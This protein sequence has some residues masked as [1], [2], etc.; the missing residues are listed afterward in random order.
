MNR[1][2]ADELLLQISKLRIGIAK[3]ER[4]KQRMIER[5]VGVKPHRQ[6]MP[7]FFPHPRQRTRTVILQN[8]HPVSVAYLARRQDALLPAPGREIELPRI[9]RPRWALKHPRHANDLPR[10]QARIRM[11]DRQKNSAARALPTVIRVNGPD[12]RHSRLLRQQRPQLRRRR[13]KQSRRLVQRKLKLGEFLAVR[14]VIGNAV[15]RKL[16]ILDLRR[17]KTHP[18]R[19][20]PQQ[21]NARQR[22][23]NKCRQ[24]DQHSG[25][26]EPK[27]RPTRK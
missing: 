3:N 2:R 16:K 4:P 9:H 6:Q 17:G 25:A 10:P 13:R 14:C 11:L 23:A 27:P 18:K 5:A 19:R 20:A 22:P 15:R 1:P 21:Y 7:R 24:N 8:F 12:H 26:Y